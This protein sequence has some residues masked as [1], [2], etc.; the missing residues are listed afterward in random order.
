MPLNPCPWTILLSS[1]DIV[2]PFFM[3]SFRKVW[4]MVDLISMLVLHHLPQT[5]RECRKLYLPLMDEVVRLG[6]GG[7]GSVY[8]LPQGDADAV[9]MMTAIKVCSISDR[10]FLEQAGFKCD[11][12]GCV[13]IN[14][15]SLPSNNASAPF[16][17]GRL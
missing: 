3:I 13:E 8:L 6:Q 4:R 15:M 1:E 7:Q 9:K 14:Y 12:E 10:I 2:L 16:S 17:L 11:Q 5:S